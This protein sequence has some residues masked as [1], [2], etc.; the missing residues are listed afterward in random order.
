LYWKPQNDRPTVMKDNAPGHC[1][2]SMKPFA[3]TMPAG[4]IAPIP[5]QH[6]IISLL[7]FL[8]CVHLCNKIVIKTFLRMWQN[9]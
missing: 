4:M 7:Q 5:E 6:V 9:T 3:A 1:V 2:Q 8:S